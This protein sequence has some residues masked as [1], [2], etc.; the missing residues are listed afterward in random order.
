MHLEYREGTG[1]A[2][3]RLTVEEKKLPGAKPASPAFTQCPIERSLNA[4]R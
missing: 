2:E 1:L 4:L 3:L